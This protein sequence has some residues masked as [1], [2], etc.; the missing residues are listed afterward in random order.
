MLYKG[1]KEFILDDNQV[2]ASIWIRLLAFFIDWLLIIAVFALIG[3]IL[4]YFD[5]QFKTMYISEFNNVEFAESKMDSTTKAIL[6]WSLSSVPILY[7]TLLM[8][9]SKGRTLGKW[10]L[11]LRILSIYHSQVSFWHCLERSLGYVASTLE[12]GLG[13]LQAF[14]NPNRMSLHD[15]IAETV[16]IRLPGKTK[17][18]VDKDTI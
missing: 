5:V 15:K 7:F 6:T 4:K 18:K 10:I 1:R 3:N 17:K 13:F 8:Y 9:F 2:L 11:G 12:G 16:V 14:W